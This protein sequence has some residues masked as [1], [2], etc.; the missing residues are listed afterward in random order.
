MTKQ[1][2]NDGP[3]TAKWMLMKGRRLAGWPFIELGQEGKAKQTKPHPARSL[4][5]QVRSDLSFAR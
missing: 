1:L 4:N 5:I 2:F 3:L